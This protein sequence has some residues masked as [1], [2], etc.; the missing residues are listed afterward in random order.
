MS[1]YATYAYAT[2]DDYEL[3]YGYG[4]ECYGDGDVDGNGGSVMADFMD[5][6][7]LFWKVISSSL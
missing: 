6:R 7:L 2:Y 5:G 4:D 3:C 1:P